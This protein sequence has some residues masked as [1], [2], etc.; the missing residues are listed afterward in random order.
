[1]GIEEINRIRN[2]AYFITMRD[3]LA[4]VSLFAYNQDCPGLTQEE[5]EQLESLCDK[6]DDAIL[7]Y[8]GKE[9]LN[10]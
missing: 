5:C 8:L 4:S 3:H 1:M 2:I 9:L 6:A 10:E 7:Q